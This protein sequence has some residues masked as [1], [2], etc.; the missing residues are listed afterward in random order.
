MF[1]LRHRDAQSGALRSFRLYICIP[2][3]QCGGQ[4][5]VL[6]AEDERN[7]SRAYFFA[8]LDCG[9]PV[10]EGGEKLAVVDAVQGDCDDGGVVAGGGSLGS[11]GGEDA[12]S[13]F[14]ALVGEELLQLGIIIYFVG[15]V[16]LWESRGVELK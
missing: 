16:L 4:R 13:C 8:V 10:V 7:E 2:R 14:V 6:D 5:A 3:V 12:G 9:Y 15:C 11:P 1:E